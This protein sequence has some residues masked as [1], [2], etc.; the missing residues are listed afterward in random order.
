MTPRPFQERAMTACG[1][2]FRSGK[3][4][5]VLVSPTGSGKTCMG[6]MMVARLV[7]QGKR[8]AWGAHRVELVE[9]AAETL[10]S[11]GLPVGL[12]GL[13]QSAPVQLGMFQQWSSRK[14]APDAD[15]A[16]FDECHHLADKNGWTDIQRAYRARN[17]K[18]IGLTATPARADGQAL[19]EFDAIVVAAQ[20]S[21]LQALGLLVPLRIKS[22]HQTLSTKHIARTPAEAY[23]LYAL[24]RSTVVFAPHVKA[25][26]SYLDDFNHRGVSCAL[27]TGAM[28]FDKRQAALYA[29]GTGAIQVLV[30][31]N[32]LTEG[33]DCPR[34]SCIIIARGCGSQGLW[35]QMTGRALRPFDGKLDAL[36]LDLRGLTHLHGRPDEDRAYFLDGDGIRLARSRTC[37]ERSCKVCG[38][39]LGDGSTCLE[40]GKEHEQIV[41]KA[42]GADLEDWKE[43]YEAAK[44]VVAPNKMVLSLAGIL[45]KAAASAGAGKPWKEGAAKF[46]FK[47][48]FK[49]WP[50][51]AEMASARNLNRTVETYPVVES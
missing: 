51:D 3:Q 29:F 34:C 36:L 11:F 13:S 22:P 14:E 32:V 50:S 15:W 4:G 26:Q 47:L 46:R 9:Q 42:T 24:G 5:V 43:R 16:I 27:V 21:E 20:I 1:A 19:P 30:N 38:A 33:W 39:P 49:R 40:C 35:I 12:R 41:P 25:A 10:R 31:V 23:E 17:T 28:P 7:A 8:V 2:E 6:A 44:S 37:A 45:R 18:A 48:I